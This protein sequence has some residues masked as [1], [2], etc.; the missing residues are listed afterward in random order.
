[1]Q[2]LIL[3]LLWLIIGSSTCLLLAQNKTTKTEAKEI[4]IHTEDNQVI[5]ATTNPP[6]QFLNG[7]VNLYHANTF[8]YCDNAILK[9]SDLRM[10]TNVVLLQNDTIKIFADSLHYNGDSLV[11]YLYGDIIMEN[12]LNK[13]MYTTYLK[14]D[15]KN[16]IAYYTQNAKLIDNTSSIISK[17]GRYLLNEKKAYFYENVLVTGEDFDLTTDSLEYSTTTERTK[18]LAP[19]RI[20]SDTSQVYSDSGWFDLDDKIGDFIGNAQYLEGNTIAKADTITYNSAQDVVILKSN[21]KRSE[22]VSDKDTALANIIYFDKKNDVFRLTTNAW[23]K[24][25]TNEVRGDQIFYDKKTEKFNVA[26][27][28]FVSDPPTLIEADSLD[29]DKSIKYGIANGHVIWRDTSAKTAIIADHVV[30]RGEESFMKATNDIGKPLFTTEIDGDTLF[31]RADT[32]RSFRVIKERLITPNLNDQRK[33]KLDKQKKAANT[34]DTIIVSNIIPQDSIAADVQNKA[35]A[36]ASKTPDT[37][38]IKELTND[39]GAIINIAKDTI[40][41]DTITTFGIRDTI[42]TGIMDTI[43]YF[44]G[45]NNVRMFKSDMQAVCDSLVFNK[46]DSLFTLHTN[47]FVWSDSSQIAGDTID[48][49]M[50]NNKVDRL[51]VRSSA[52]I[53]SSEDLVYYNQIKGRFMQSF[54]KDGKIYRMDVNGNAQIVYYL[55]DKEKAYI[56]VNTTESSYMSFFLSDNEITDIRCYKEPKSKVIPMKKAD[57]EGLKVK[58]FQWNASSR[59]KKASD[60]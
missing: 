33:A 43:D 19:V 18:F 14:Y 32:L 3:S 2:R 31:L 51:V 45:D 36:K 1:M 16:K 28:S 56:G 17:K 10:Y 25:E 6:T 46:S 12:G 34:V 27:R 60:L 21:N 53:I 23:Y 22:Y 42:H 24:G 35:L 52:T 5:D 11:A 9:G 55:T 38:V 40:A 41:L 7:N 20:N 54:F 13:K 15:V 29:Y 26:G 50:K 49:I 30:Y 8:M 39:T 37:L 47:P 44:I 59:P 48:I 4:T 57:H 58:G